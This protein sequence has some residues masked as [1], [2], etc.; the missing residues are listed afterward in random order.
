[1]KRT[2]SDLTN[3]II[4][5]EQNIDTYNNNIK[6]ECN[7]VLLTTVELDN[8]DLKQ[9]QEDT[10]KQFEVWKTEFL[11]DYNDSEYYE[12]VLALLNG[13]Q[14][15][16][17]SVKCNTDGHMDNDDMKFYSNR[18]L[19]SLNNQ[20][21]LNFHVMVSEENNLNIEKMLV[22][23]EGTF[24]NV[25]TT[26]Y[27]DKYDQMADTV[28]IDRDTLIRLISFCYRTFMFHPEMPSDVYQMVTPDQSEISTEIQGLYGQYRS[29]NFISLMSRY[30]EPNREKRLRTTC[31][32]PTFEFN[33][34]FDEFEEGEGEGEVEEGQEGSF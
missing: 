19:L 21:F 32:I 30:T 29:N 4:A 8:Y 28:G 7:T 18:L 26:D 9:H 17:W 6:K 16:N 12:T 24:I 10:L 11:N 27:Y 22:S 13:Y 25:L 1:M 33:P 15:T 2:R 14:L 5:S 3:T 34:L 23:C 31:V 20:L